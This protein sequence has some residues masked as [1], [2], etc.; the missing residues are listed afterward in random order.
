MRSVSD[1]ASS[2]EIFGEAMRPLESVATML[3]ESDRLRGY[4]FEILLLF[5]KVGKQFVHRAAWKSTG[6]SRRTITLSL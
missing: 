2:P 4:A 3:I 5:E 6:H 1:F